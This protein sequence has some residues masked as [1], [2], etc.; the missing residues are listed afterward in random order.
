MKKDPSTMP[1]SEREELRLRRQR[2][3][4]NRK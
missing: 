1:F 2:K 4:K 3:M